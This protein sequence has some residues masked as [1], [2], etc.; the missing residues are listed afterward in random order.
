MHLLA[1]IRRAVR[2]ERFVVSDH[3]DERLRERKIELWQIIAGVDNGKLLRERLDAR[4]LPTV[5]IEQV[6][7]DG[8][9]V[10]AVWGW[11][12]AGNVAKLIT[13]HL[14]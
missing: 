7:P 13:V 1:D 6:L 3:A 14:L 10:K 9:T 2:D 11:W 8:T 5:E 4:P 12:A